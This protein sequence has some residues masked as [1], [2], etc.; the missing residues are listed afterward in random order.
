MSAGSALDASHDLPVSLPYRQFD[1]LGLPNTNG[2]RGGRLVG[3]RP[4]WLV[5]CNLEGGIHDLLSGVEYLEHRA[6][7]EGQMSMKKKLCSN[8][9]V[10]FAA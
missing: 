9:S 7:K 1:A 3:T 4:S 8:E 2:A 10:A 5:V 6:A